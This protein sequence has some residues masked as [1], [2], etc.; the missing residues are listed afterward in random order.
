M[1]LLPKDSLKLHPS[2]C[3]LKEELPQKHPKCCHLQ[4]IHQLTSIKSQTQRWCWLCHVPGAVAS[5]VQVLLAGS[6]A[7]CRWLRTGLEP[8]GT[9]MLTHSPASH[10][11]C[12]TW[13]YAQVCFWVHSWYC[14]AHPSTGRKVSYSTLA[15]NVLTL[16]RRGTFPLLNSL[17][18]SASLSRGKQVYKSATSLF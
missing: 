9:P 7:P 4:V 8:L 13:A 18:C 17:V 12:D 5:G 11:V 14:I 3:L 15:S 6:V 1:D 16:N 2:F 10:C